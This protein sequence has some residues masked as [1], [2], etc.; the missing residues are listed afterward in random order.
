MGLDF[1]HGSAH[2]AYSGFMRFWEMLAREEGFELREMQGYH[3][4]RAWDT[5]QTDLEP[6]LNHSDCD[7]ELTPQ[8]CAQVAPRLREILAKWKEE[9]THDLADDDYDVYAGLALC[10][11]MEQCAELGEVL[12]FC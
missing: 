8:E 5:V 2:W 1:S 9:R 4:D 12:E 7:G 10:D 11:A 3:G 6:L